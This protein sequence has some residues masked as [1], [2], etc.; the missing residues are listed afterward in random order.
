MVSAQAAEAN[1][2]ETKATT[3]RVVTI[4][5][6]DFTLIVMISTPINN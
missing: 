4:R 2:N 5:F 3:A 6:L 1:N